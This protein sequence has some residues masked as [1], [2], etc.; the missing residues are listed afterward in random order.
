MIM[1]TPTIMAMMTVVLSMDGLLEL[2]GETELG[3]SLPVARSMPELVSSIT[4]EGFTG[5]VR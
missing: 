1:M 2:F 3:V 5:F 4:G